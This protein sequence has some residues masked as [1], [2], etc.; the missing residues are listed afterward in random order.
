[1]KRTMSR[2]FARYTLLLS[3][4]LGLHGLLLAQSKVGT[5][6]AQ[7][8]SISV[9]P[10][11]IAMGSAYVAEN[12]DVT[13]LYWNPGAFQQA[14][15]S[16][17]MFSH[18]NW[19]VG[20]NF[21]WLGFM[22]RLGEDNAVGLS[23]TQLDYGEEDVTSVQM[24]EGTGEK[25]T[26]QDLAFGLSYSRRLT[27][28]FA[29]GGSV[30]YVRQQIW[31]ESATAWAFDL[32]LLFVTG[33]NGMRLGVSMTNFGGDL[34]LEGSDLTRQVDIDPSNSGSNKNLVGYLKTDPWPM[35]L[36][37]R[38]G[39]AMDV[40]KG[41]QFIAT[42]AADA[43]R[44]SDMGESVNVG[45][46][47]GW[48]KMVF[49]RAGYRGAVNNS[50]TDKEDGLTFGA[51]LHYALEGVGGIGVDYAYMQFGAFGNLSTIAVSVNF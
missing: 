38:V 30:K 46:E 33:F 42:L 1:M 34:Q 24:P 29:M 51:G 16:E 19:L 18:T 43:V 7:F 22:L 44:P 36:T 35:P 13:S 48:N 28:F 11:A 4:I 15:K 3:L 41:D 47:V 31:N 2:R 40:L 12:T 49:V 10:R 14:G 45:T 39:L 26:A 17:A 21:R 50:K 9:G 23:L 37:F 20:T 32:G 5:S 8:L 27:D 25:W 6:A